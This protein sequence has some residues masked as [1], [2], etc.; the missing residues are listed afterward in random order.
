MLFESLFKHADAKPHE[1][2]V[3]DDTG[4]YSWQQLAAAAAGLGMYLSV[5]TD[6]PRV[7]LLLPTGMGFAASFYGTLLAGK[8]VVPINFLLGD[9]EVQHIIADSG[10][11]TIVSIPL[12]S[13]RL[14]DTPLKIVDLQQ[15]QK[16]APPPG[17]VTPKFPDVKADDM[18]VLMY[19][20]GTSGLPK[21]VEITYGNLSSDVD[22]AIEH[23]QLK[24]SHRFLGIVPLF[25][26]TGLLATLVAPVKLGAATVYQARFSPVAVMKAIREQQISLLVAV[27]SMYGALARLKDAGPD[28]VKSLYAAI[29][30]GEPLPSNIRLA[31]EKKFGMPLYEGYG[32]T[33][34]IG[35]IAFN[36]PGAVK[37]GAVGRAIPNAEIRMTDEE[38]KAVAKG[39]TGEVWLR[40]PM[41]MRGYHNLPDET[42]RALTADGYFKTGDLG[43][44]DADG[45]L[46]I[47]GRKKD[48]II[49][50]GEK[51][52]PR[53]IEEVIMKHPSV[54]DVAVVGKRDPSRGEVVVAFVTAKADQT[55]KADEIRDF[56]RQQGLAQ[57]KCPREIFVEKSLPVSPTGKVL[58]RELQARVNA[59][60][61][62]PVG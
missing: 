1:I 39:E 49:V 26:S 17:A 29:S 6:R 31:F 36:V 8:A 12:L 60:P 15:L 48:I 20:S 19:T 24:G 13:A 22:S 14:K 28:D 41:I 45:Y 42:A 46:F 40:G 52:A 43:H 37:P 51:A 55:V 10:I 50:A 5:Q 30:G 25:H 35:P 32:L 47:T 56:C 61:A 57:W 18:C 62:N 4:S 27:P 3:T 53:E 21:G 58:K 59:D 38:G 54:A 44:I 11:D 2:A 34:T 33:E 16:M 23:A 9:R 7:G